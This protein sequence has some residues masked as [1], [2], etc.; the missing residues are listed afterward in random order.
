MTSQ[1]VRNFVRHD[2]RDTCLVLTDRQNAFVE[3]DFSARQ[4]EG[5]LR[6]IG[7]DSELPIEVRAEVL[8]LGGFSQSLADSRHDFVVLGVCRDLVL[9]FDF[10]V[11]G[12][13]HLYL[14]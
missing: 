12:D 2:H 5:V 8:S 7:D 9:C 6:L 10:V 11:G 3:R 4:T 1:R 13:A 14:L